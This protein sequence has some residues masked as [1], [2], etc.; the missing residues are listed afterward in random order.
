[1][2]MNVIL[3]IGIMIAA[4]FLGGA[5]AAK[6]NFP[7]ITGYLIVGILLSPSVLNVIPEAMVHDF[8]IVTSVALG[9]IAYLIGGSLRLESVRKLGRSIAWIT[10]LQGITPWFL[11][12]LVITFVAPFILSIPD[13]TLASTYFPMAFVL[14]AI[15]LATAPAATIAI[16]REMNAK[17]P[18]STTLLAVVALDDVIAIVAF[19]IAAGVAEPLMTAGGVFSVYETLA[20]PFLHIAESVAIGA[21]FGLAIVYMAKL[22]KTRPLLIVVVLAAI[23]LCIGITELWGGSLLLA[24]MVVGFIVAN[25]AGSDEMVSGMQEIEEIIFVVF[26]V[27]AGMHFDSSTLRAAG[28][29][30]ALIILCRSGGKYL[31]ARAGA[32]I[33][34]AP[35]VVRK[36]LGLGLL[37]KAGVTIG[38]G[39]LLESL[40]PTVGAVMFNAL[41]A[42]TIIN[43]L[44]APPLTKYVIMKADERNA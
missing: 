9:I 5:I 11:T 44:V 3:A 39:L 28:I 23:I 14:G 34:G 26:F 19:A 29:I 40:F 10:A 20:V 25:K 16:I 13:A 35:E 37:P 22:V 1:M 33:S 42:S 8:D 17:G 12:T 4:G 32:R 7:R 36:Y 18:L 30:A 6:V 27:L 41:L 31:G 24:N 2:T 21:V 43:E 38:L 15:A